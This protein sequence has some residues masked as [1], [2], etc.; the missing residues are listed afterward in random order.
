MLR[1]AQ[2]LLLIA[3]LGLW[4]ASRVTWVVVTSFDGLSPARTT[5]VP[6]GSWSTAL[7]PLALI[8][9]AA[10]VA[11]LAVRSWPLRILAALVALVSAA[12]AYLGISTW[13]LPDVAP[14][15][16]ELAQVPVTS[17][18]EAQ[19]HYLGAVITLVAAV[20][21]LVAAV[22]MMRVGTRAGF[23]AEKYAGAAA[24]RAAAADTEADDTS[25]R[26]LW[27]ALDDGVDPTADAADS[28]PT[29]A[30]ERDTEGR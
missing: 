21:A 7:V 25:E 3:A 8:L 17:L 20:V 12:T 11:G 27:D 10:A 9:L 13:V 24:R 28:S 1:T 26:T 22:L 18:V 2:L 23:A 29:H 14:R 19:R 6:G 4:G 15:A 16:I 5:T 30:P